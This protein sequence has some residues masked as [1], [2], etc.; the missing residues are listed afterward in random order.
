MVYDDPYL[1]YHSAIRILNILGIVLGVLSVVLILKSVKKIAGKVASSYSFILVG[2]SLQTL[3]LILSRMFD[4]FSELLIV[5]F[6]T[7]GLGVFIIGVKK[8]SELSK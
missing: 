5:L 8:F 4:N 7:L 3:G 2:I 1:L 6:V